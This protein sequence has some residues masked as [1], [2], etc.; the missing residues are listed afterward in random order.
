MLK[1]KRSWIILLENAWKTAKPC[2]HISQTIG[3]HG[4]AMLAIYESMNFQWSTVADEPK[5]FVSCDHRRSFLGHIKT[6]FFVFWV[7]CGSTGGRWSF[8]IA[9]KQHMWTLRRRWS[10]TVADC[11]RS[12][13]RHMRTRLYTSFTHTHVFFLAFQNID[14]IPDNIKR[15]YKT[16]WEISQKTL[17]NMA[18][19]R[20]AFIDQS[21]SFNVFIAEPNFGK[22]T[23]MHFYGWKKVSSVCNYMETILDP[24]C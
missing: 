4:L 16:A 5:K 2:S 23:S 19:D 18:A 9:D 21:Q 1:D 15:L 14:K 20:G 10:Q 3:D 6:N 24:G 17:I 13:L 8:I 11:L 22:L 12:G 7:T